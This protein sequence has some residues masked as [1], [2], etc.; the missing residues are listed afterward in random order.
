MYPHR[1]ESAHPKPPTKG[2]FRSRSGW[3]HPMRIALARSRLDSNREGG[4][5]RRPRPAERNGRPA[6][7]LEPPNRVPYP[8]GHSYLRS[9]RIKVRG[10]AWMGNLNT[11]LRSSTNSALISAALKLRID[12]RIA[13]ILANSN[14]GRQN[15]L[16]I[17]GELRAWPWRRAPASIA[18]IWP[19]QFV[20]PQRF[21][22]RSG[23][24]MA[25][26]AKPS[27]DLMDLAL[28]V[29]SSRASSA[30]SAHL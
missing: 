30:V 14:R 16:L 13:T 24:E 20:S 5:Q 10:N 15:I 8:L 12:G 6:L 9:R 4:D 28:W 17:A 26:G 11:K 21:R 22:V 19:Y 2:G 7:R 3:E 1:T 29:M 25:I 18:V 23:G 27:R